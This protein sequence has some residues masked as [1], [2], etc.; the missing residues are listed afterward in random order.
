MLAKTKRTITSFRSFVCKWCNGSKKFCFILSSREYLTSAICRRDSP[1]SM[2]ASANYI[3][4]KEQ[5]INWTTFLNRYI[6][7]CLTK[8]TIFAQFLAIQQHA[9][10]QQTLGLWVGVTFS[11]T[12]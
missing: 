6:N 2:S 9:V 8:N 5:K 4:W 1:I 12:G 10:S 11:L 7:Y 3:K